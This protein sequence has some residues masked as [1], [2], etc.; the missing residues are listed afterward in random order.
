M[1][2][3]PNYNAD[4][5]AASLLITYCSFSSLILS[6]VV[7]ISFYILSKRFFLKH[8]GLSDARVTSITKKEYDFTVY[9]L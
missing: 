2:I 3:F 5:F 1:F 8:E 6:S 7:M 9:F 4:I